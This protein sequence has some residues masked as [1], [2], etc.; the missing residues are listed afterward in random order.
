MASFHLTN[1]AVEDLA[2]IWNYTIDKWSENQADHYYQMLLDSCQNIATGRVIG[3]NYDGIFKSLLGI[4]VGKHI[5]FYR[6]IASD[7]VE[8]VRILHEQ[9]DLRNRILEK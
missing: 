6:K 8:I 5:V 7:A 4:R 9:M 1:K 2:E 3:K